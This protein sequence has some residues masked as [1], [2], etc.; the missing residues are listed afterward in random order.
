[1]KKRFCVA[2]AF[3]GLCCVALILAADNA[4]C[5]D[6]SDRQNVFY[7]NSYSNGYIWSDSLMEGLK[8]VFA[9]SE[10]NIALH[11]EYMDS[12][13]RY[14]DNVKM[15]L[16]GIYA[17]KYKGIDIDAIIVS[18][19]NAF[20]F[21]LQ[22]REGLFPGVPVIFCGVNDFAPA[23]TRGQKNITGLTEDFDVKTNLRMALRFH[24]E[25]KKI[26][27]IGNSSTT[28][29]A[30]GNQVRAAIADFHD[31]PEIEF[32]VSDQLQPILDQ[33]RAV[34]DEAIFY[35]IPFY[36]DY[37]GVRYSANEI[38]SKLYA[39]TDAPI[40]SNWEF[41]L[42]S[43]IVGGKV[44]SGFAHGAAAG[45]LLMRVFRGE[46]IDD[47][48]VQAPRDEPY[49]FDNNLLKRF[50][51]STSDLPPEST[52]INHTSYLFQINRQLFW[53]LVIGMTVITVTLVV[54]MF[55]ISERRAIEQRIKEQLAFVKL[56]MNTIPIP[57]YFKDQGGVV[58]E[59]N[60]TFEKWFDLERRNIIGRNIKSFSASGPAQL[61]HQID[62]DLLSHDGV[63]IYET[64]LTAADR[65]RRDVILHKASYSN[66][67]GEISGLVGVIFDITARKKAERELIKAEEK[68]RSIFEN[69]AL[70]IFRSGADGRILDANPA[71]ANMLGF[72][73]LAELTAA[74]AEMPGA[75]CL[76]PSEEPSSGDR[77]APVTFERECQTRDGRR[78]I[79]TQHLRSVWGDDGQIRYYEGFI[80]DITQRK[81]AEKNLNESQQMLKLVLDNIPQLV[82]WKD[83]DLRY[84]G[85]NKSFGAFFG[86][87]DVDAIIGKCDID[88]FPEKEEAA[89]SMATD[90][91]VAATNQPSYRMRWPVHN[92]QG[93]QKWMLVNRVPLHNDRGEVVGVLSSAEDITQN[94]IMERRML[95]STKMEAIGTLA[96]GIAH[97][98]NNILTSIYNSTELALEDVAPDSQTGRDLQR[99]LK[100]AERGSQLVQQI[101][102]FSRAD[103][104]GIRMMDI[105]AV[106]EEA[107]QLIS[108]SL[109]G[110]IDVDVH[111][112]PQLSPCMADPTQIHQIVM[113]LC[114]NSFQALKGA[115]GQIRI[116]L[117]HVALDENAAELL[118]IQPGPYLKLSI[119]DNGPG[120]PA[121]IMDKIFDPFFTTKGKGEGTGLGLA[122]AHGIIK[123]HNGA[124][125]VTS[126]PGF[127][128]TFDIFLPTDSGAVA[129]ANQTQSHVY[130]GKGRIL[131]VEDDPDQLEII[132]RVLGK[133]GYQ[134]EARNG[135]RAAQEAIASTREP[136]NLVITDFD[137]PDVNGIELAKAIKE[138]HPETPIMMVTGRKNPVE[139]ASRIDSIRKV[140]IKP[141]NK[142]ILSEAIREVLDE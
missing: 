89:K 98:F 20:D 123:G 113:N 7:L 31:R 49:M 3:R 11:I 119:S 82:H 101:L 112:E 52:L 111:I 115:G 110:N 93:E 92:H 22:F 72:D 76:K 103:Q 97:D 120:I 102:T 62:S 131:F 8:S 54:L 104:E 128:T 126:Q 69:S 78:I 9:K 132:P 100:A 94:I 63:R 127:D 133:L 90:R 140:I 57:I 118:G 65:T 13:Q 142:A 106:V 21:M 48:P 33:A 27:V 45:E 36:M 122:V 23:M 124:A 29:R 99:S 139:L 25:R 86:L 35:F 87:R 46:K 107:V 71:L 80:E 55:N 38:L 34:A 116:M 28:G 73:S 44:L 60:E 121:D 61:T 125:R 59:C 134:V 95:E 32:V 109:P 1:M 68:Y 91:S 2:A 5:A 43:G 108:A 66:A 6:N 15:S 135:G 30:I 114:T 136:F 67:K 117:N 77:L 58:T 4:L 105:A 50:K 19:N 141:Y 81:T 64:S 83:L 14:D 85:A 40:Y 26:V 42:G 47:I 74:G 41:M 137:M 53:V 129:D 24:P 16:Y 51:I 75:L 18:D 79:V 138:K 56:L 10:A 70:G 37:E 17:H 12:K 39:T 84:L 96:G 130:R 88:L